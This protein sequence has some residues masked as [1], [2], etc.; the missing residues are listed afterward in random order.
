MV[1]GG[2]DDEVESLKQSDGNLKT[3]H[4]V[5]ERCSD[6]THLTQSFHRRPHRRV[7]DHRA[8]LKAGRVFVHLPDHRVEFGVGK[9]LHRVQNLPKRNSV[10]IGETRL[11]GQ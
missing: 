8:V 7:N 6:E 5:I 4:L 9:L 11:L 1:I 10:M 2:I 3:A